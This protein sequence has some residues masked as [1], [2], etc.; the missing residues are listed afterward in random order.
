MQVEES[1]AATQRMPNQSMPSIPLVQPRPV[2][3]AHD[4][5]SV[6]EVN[7]TTK[8]S[9]AAVSSDITAPHKQPS[10]DFYPLDTLVQQ[11]SALYLTPLLPGALSLP[12][13]Q[14][15]KENRRDTGD[16]AGS[17]RVSFA[18]PGERNELLPRRPSPTQEVSGDQ[19]SEPGAEQNPSM[20]ST[21]RDDSASEL[22]PI[23]RVSIGRVEVRTTIAPAAPATKR[24]APASPALS[25]RD[26]LQRRKGGVG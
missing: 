26:Y 1:L 12:S 13:E 21:R 7:V 3:A 8:T 4:N 24:A 23:I 22:T 25:L 20:A 19:A 14:T 15:G 9:E 6:Q 5:G 2:L 10:Y 11:Q 18:A 17:E 16:A